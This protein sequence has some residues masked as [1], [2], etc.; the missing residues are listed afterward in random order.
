MTSSFQ[1]NPGR[2]NRTLTPGP[3]P[4]Q[5]KPGPFSRPWA[6]LAWHRSHLLDLGSITENQ[7]PRLGPW[8]FQYNLGHLRR[9]TLKCIPHL[10]S[11]NRASTVELLSPSSI[12]TAL[13][14]GSSKPTHAYLHL[15]AQEFGWQVFTLLWGMSLK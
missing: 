15:A 11:R 10:F 6:L 3:W 7:A 4:N 14:E 12:L 13:M 5:Q 8:S 2:I 9:M 1:Q